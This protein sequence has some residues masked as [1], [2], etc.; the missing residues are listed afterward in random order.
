[1]GIGEKP[2]PATIVV[3]AGNDDYR[4]AL[5]LDAGNCY[6]QFRDLDE[7][8]GAICS[9]ASSLKPSTKGKSTVWS[10]HTERVAIRRIADQLTVSPIDELR[11]NRSTS[12]SHTSFR[13]GLKKPNRRIDWYSGWTECNPI[14]Q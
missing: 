7:A 1:M 11:R 8:T 2:E 5:D 6:Y 3:D 14:R 9:L 13:R 4:I 10:S 12:N